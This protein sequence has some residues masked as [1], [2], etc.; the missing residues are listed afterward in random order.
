MNCLKVKTV[1]LKAKKLLTNLT[2][3]QVGGWCSS[4]GGASETQIIS[5]TIEHYENIRNTMKAYKKTQEIY[6]ICM[7]QF[8]LLQYQLQISK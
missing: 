7:K 2:N 3:N 8:H 1:M 4:R 5:L 6:I